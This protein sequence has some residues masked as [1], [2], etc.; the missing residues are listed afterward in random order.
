MTSS[1]RR[2]KRV[3]LVALSFGLLLAG[4]LWQERDS[5]VHAETLSRLIASGAADSSTLVKGQ[6]VPGTLTQRE[7]P[8]EVHLCINT[9]ESERVAIH[10]P[11]CL[12]EEQARVLPQWAGLIEARGQLAG[13]G[14]LQAET[15][16]HR[17]A[18][19]ERT[20]R[21]DHQLGPPAHAQGTEIGPHSS[22]W[23]SPCETDR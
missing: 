10:Y 1:P 20:T 14:T 2:S 7:D 16:V 15:L 23:Q 12:S 22:R 8:C 17:G 18:A 11:H 3:A 13:H 9:V 21:A 19:P 4:L 6:L 5:L